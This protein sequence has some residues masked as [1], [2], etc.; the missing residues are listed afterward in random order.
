MAIV[1][2]TETGNVPEPSY[3]GITRIV[4]PA[5]A[6]ITGDMATAASAAVIKA[7]DGGRRPL[8]LVISGVSSIT[9]EARTVYGGATVSTAIAVVGASPVDRVIGNFLLGGAAPACPNQFFC[10]EAD[11]L[12]WLE[13]YL[14]E[15]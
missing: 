9:R 15:Q 5:G 13:R 12:A 10:S 11:A 4:L 3:E 14:D 8:M 7:A 2:M 1:T 6:T